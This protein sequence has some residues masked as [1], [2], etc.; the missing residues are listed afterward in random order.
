[1][2]EAV[3]HPRDIFSAVTFQPVQYLILCHNHPSGVVDPSASDITLT[4]RVVSAGELL[5]VRLLDHLIVSAK[6]EYS[7]RSHGRIPPEKG[8][9]V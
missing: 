3:I 2:N 1:M 5:G 8:G 7:F 6:S 4:N 9:F